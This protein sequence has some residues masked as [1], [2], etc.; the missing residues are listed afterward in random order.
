MLDASGRRLADATDVSSRT[1]LAAAGRH[2]V[3]IGDAGLQ[4]VD[5]T[6]F[7]ASKGLAAP[8]P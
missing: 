2:L 6:P 3:M 5:T 7:V 4:T 1:R 8:R